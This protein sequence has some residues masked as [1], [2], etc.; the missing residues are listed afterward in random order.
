MRILKPALYAMGG[1]TQTMLAE[2]FGVTGS[3][4][5]LVVNNRIWKEMEEVCA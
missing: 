1:Y 3:L 2:M 4:I 5:C